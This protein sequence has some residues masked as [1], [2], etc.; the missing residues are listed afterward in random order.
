[1]ASAFAGNELEASRSSFAQPMH[2]EMV[3]RS[4]RHA[5]PGACAYEFS[6]E[7]QDAEPSFNKEPG[8][9]GYSH[10]CSKDAAVKFLRFP[11]R[12]CQEKY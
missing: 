11:L 9:V 2:Q 1:M 12:S 8:Q 6:G 7:L 5:M 10:T 4:G 3:E